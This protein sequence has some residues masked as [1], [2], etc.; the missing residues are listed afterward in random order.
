MQTYTVLIGMNGAGLTNG[1]YLPPG[2]IVIQLV[3]SKLQLN[4]REF[5]RLLQGGGGGG[6]LE[7][8]NTQENK[9]VNRGG[10][11]IVDVDEIVKLAHQAVSMYD[12]SHRQNFPK[13]L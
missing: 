2:G 3:P 10:D 12:N 9:T 11:T 5:G 7:W 6:Y 8:I 13:E 1:L 4:N